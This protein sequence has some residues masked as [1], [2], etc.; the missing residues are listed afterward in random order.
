MEIWLGELLI[1]D[2]TTFHSQLLSS[3]KTKL[4]AIILC[5]PTVPVM[6][7]V[8]QRKKSVE[9]LELKHLREKSAT[10]YVL[11]ENKGTTAFRFEARTIKVSDCFTF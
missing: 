7:P 11:C 1:D 10:R 4:N 3:F 9:T 8:M 5:H 2:K 6:Q